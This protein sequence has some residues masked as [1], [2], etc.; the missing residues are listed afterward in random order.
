MREGNCGKNQYGEM[1]TK[2]CRN[3]FKEKGKSYKVNLM[4]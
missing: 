2:V 4:S 3:F 1:G